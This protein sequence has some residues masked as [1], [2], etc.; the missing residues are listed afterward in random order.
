[1]RVGNNVGV[2]VDIGELLGYEIQEPGLGESIDLGVE[3]EILEDVAHRRRERRHISAQVF[4]D[5][6]LVPPELLQVERRSIVEKLPRF[7]QEERFRI[8]PAA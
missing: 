4:A 7:P 6:V 8:E 3:V 1:L 5:V 2:K